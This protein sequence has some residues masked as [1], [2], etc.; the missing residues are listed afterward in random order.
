[1]ELEAEL[2]SIL[3]LCSTAVAQYHSI[4]FIIKRCFVSS[5]HSASISFLS[6]F[7]QHR[8]QRSKLRS[9]ASNGRARPP[10]RLRQTSAGSSSGS[11]HDG[12]PGQRELC[13]YVCVDCGEKRKKRGWRYS[14][15]CFHLISSR[16]S[17]SV[18]YFYGKLKNQKK[19]EMQIQ[20]SSLPLSRSSP[21]RHW[22]C[23]LDLWRPP[24][25]CSWGHEE[26]VFW[27]ASRAGCAERDWWGFLGQAHYF[28]IVQTCEKVAKSMHQQ[29]TECPHKLFTL[30]LCFPSTLLFLH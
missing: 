20:P 18:Q 23:A 17:L 27:G 22:G 5:S 4:F 19:P 8:G 29:N 28:R 13:A 14:P 10:P 26:G 12:G 24:F 15:G 2:H 30:G 3:L 16:D 1:M 21:N 6:L 9:A 11:E 7:S 25:L